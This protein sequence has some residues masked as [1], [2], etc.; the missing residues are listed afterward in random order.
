MEPIFKL[1]WTL[2][3]ALSW[4]SIL[5][6]HERSAIH[7][8]ISILAFQENTFQDMVEASQPRRWLYSSPQ[9]V[10][11][12]AILPQSSCGAYGI[13]YMIVGEPSQQP[14][15]HAFQYPPL[16]HKTAF[17]DEQDD[18]A[19][20][21]EFSAEFEESAEV[22]RNLKSTLNELKDDEAED[23]IYFTPLLAEIPF[24][25]YG[26]ANAVIAVQM[27]T[28]DKN[29]YSQL[30]SYSNDESSVSLPKLLYPEMSSH[31]SFII[32]CIFSSHFPTSRRNCS[33]P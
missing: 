23:N 20:I 12:F 14:T 32:G 29:A 26:G 7:D 19:I 17:G 9:P 10:Q 2:Y 11:D 22:S 24:Q 6:G 21:T 15:V 4:L 28:L 27:V 25:L 3:S 33:I 30:T 18:K 13:I 16:L 31:S 1:E 5:G 8:G